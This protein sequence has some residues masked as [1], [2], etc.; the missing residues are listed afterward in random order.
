M[1]TTPGAQPDGHNKPNGDA[2]PGRQPGDPETADG[3]ADATERVLTVIAVLL[4]IGSAATDVMAFT[5]LGSVFASVMTSNILFLGLAAAQ[6]SGTLA[7]HAAVSLAGYV[8]GVAAA[9]RLARP[10]VRSHSAAAEASDGSRSA[11]CGGGLWS[12]RIVGTLTI[13]LAVLAG[14]TVGWE[15]TGGR[16][17]GGAKF[18]LIALAAMAMG[19]QSTVVAEIGI[20]GVSTTYLTGT[21]T[22]LI[23]AIARP[24]PDRRANA[25]LAAALGAL[26]AGALLAGLLLATVPS[27]AP[28]IPLVMLVSVI[29][30][31]SVSLRAALGPQQ[32][33]FS[34]L[35]PFMAI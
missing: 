15:L 29:A 24:R 11:G 8:I 28:A 32:P 22:T 18:V 4:T 3:A 35:S 12:P 30:V 23:D 16:P 27:A 34:G 31:G 17:I 21:L 19:I 10:P 33:E 14:F 13:E 6:H 20:A 9:A 5:R 7:E 1:D 25:R 2:G 26:A